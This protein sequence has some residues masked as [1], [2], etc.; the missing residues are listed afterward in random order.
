MS[1]PAIIV[2]V[3]QGLNLLLSANRHGKEQSPENFW[4]T[5]FGVVI[6]CYLLWWGGFY[7]HQ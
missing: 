5:A 1:I 6:M 7:D 4:T 3:L 2:T